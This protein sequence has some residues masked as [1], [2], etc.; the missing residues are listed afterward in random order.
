M[1]K[2]LSASLPALYLCA[3]FAVAGARSRSLDGTWQFA[4]DR[5]GA[6]REARSSRRFA[7]S[8]HTTRTNTRGA[9]STRW[10]GLWPPACSSRSW[11]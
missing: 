4:F 11:R 10:S 2:F 3:L 7:W 6:A 9:C 5:G 1:K 8:T